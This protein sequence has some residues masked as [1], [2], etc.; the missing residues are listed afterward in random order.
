MTIRA[1]PGSV[2]TITAS[3]GKEYLEIVRIYAG[4]GY[5]FTQL[6][7]IPHLHYGT[8]GFASP[9]RPLVWVR[10][11]MIVVCAE[12][13]DE[14][15][16]ADDLAKLLGHEPADVRFWPLGDWWRAFR[17]HKEQGCDVAEISD[18][19][20]YRLAFLCRTCAMVVRAQWD[21]C[22][23]LALSLQAGRAEAS[24]RLDAEEI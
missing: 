4:R 3:D 7:D 19:L 20:T 10:T 23:D 8:L 13:D 12:D 2:I 18:P 16:E 14:G 15:F 24:S 17:Q 11:P 21:D 5:C 6:D 22:I 1:K 9:D